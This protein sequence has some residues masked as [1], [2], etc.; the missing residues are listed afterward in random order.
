ML[1]IFTG[2][3]PTWVL[4]VYSLKLNNNNYI[5][6]CMHFLMKKSFLPD[7]T[8]LIHSYNNDMAEVLQVKMENQ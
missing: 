4:I 7:M 3:I 8:V 5:G 6:N 2:H 1:A